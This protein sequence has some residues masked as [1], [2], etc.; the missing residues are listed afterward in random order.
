MYCGGGGGEG[1]DCVFI[2]N[3]MDKW[4]E[5]RSGISITEWISGRMLDV[6][7]NIS[8]VEDCDSLIMNVG[9]VWI[10]MKLELVQ[11]LWICRGFL[12]LTL[13][14]PIIIE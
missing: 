8:G 6:H 7:K 3:W 14:S 1:I 10:L 11:K 5:Q 2:S 4:S 13:K 9:G 12:L